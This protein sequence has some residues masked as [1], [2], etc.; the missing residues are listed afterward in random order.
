MHSLRFLT[1][2]RIRPSLLGG[3]SRSD[4]YATAALKRPAASARCRLHVAHDVEMQN[5]GSISETTACLKRI[6]EASGLIFEAFELSR[7]DAHLLICVSFAKLL[8]VA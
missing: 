3:S 5:S 6:N 4:A 2:L 8:K 1:Q 7:I